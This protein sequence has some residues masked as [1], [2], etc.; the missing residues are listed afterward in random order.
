MF[1]FL[2]QVIYVSFYNDVVSPGRHFCVSLTGRYGA[3]LEY[4]LCFR[5]AGDSP[6]A[7]C[8]Q[9]VRIINIMM[10][11]SNNLVF[12]SELLITK[13]LYLQLLWFYYFPVR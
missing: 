6:F 10:M 11:L 3:F 13:V 8:G 12:N 1:F 4:L 9:R 5:I 2:S 7:V